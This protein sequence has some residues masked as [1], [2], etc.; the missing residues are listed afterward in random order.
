MNL[1][2]TLTTSVSHRVLR[3]GMRAGPQPLQPLHGAVI[4][5]PRGHA[6]LWWPWLRLRQS[7]GRICTLSRTYTVSY[8]DHVS[9]VDT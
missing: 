7:R 1:L 5:P 8:S 6:A 3:S 4:G 2:Q 9:H